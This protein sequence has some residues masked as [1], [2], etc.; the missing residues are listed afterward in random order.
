MWHRTLLAGRLEAFVGV[1]A[2]VS[3]ILKKSNDR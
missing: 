1:L 2:V 3:E